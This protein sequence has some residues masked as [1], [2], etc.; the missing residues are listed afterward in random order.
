MAIAYLEEKGCE[1]EVI[2]YL[3]ELPSKEELKSVLKKLDIPASELVR[4]GESI[5]KE[6][7]RGKEL[8]QDEWVDAMLAHPKLIERPIVIK[9]N[10]AIVAR[11]TDRIEELV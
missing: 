2:E 1:I 7:Y 9:S 11:P 3:K 8:S 6:L 4:K 5:F 10:K